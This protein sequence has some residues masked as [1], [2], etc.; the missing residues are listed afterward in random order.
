[1]YRVIVFFCLLLVGCLPAAAQNNL[2]EINNVNSEVLQ[3]E[4]FVFDVGGNKLSGLLDRPLDQEPQSTIVIVH[5]YGE[6]K[7]V[8][9]D[10]YRELRSQFAG[11]GMNVLIWDKPGCGDSE[12]E[13]DINQPVQSSAEEVVAAVQA[14]KKRDIKGTDKIGLWGISRAGWIAPLAMAQ[15]TSIAFW[16]SVSGTDDKENARYLL[17]SNWLAEGRS[18]EE[19]EVL[20]SEWQARFNTAWRNGTYQE[21]LDAAPNLSSDEFMKFMG[22][23]GDA[24]E[25]EFLAY[26]DKFNSGEL[27]VDEQ[28]ELMIYVPDFRKLLGSIN[29]PVLALFGE[30]DTNVDWRKTAALYRETLGANPAAS[31]RISTFPDGNHTL[32]QS[33][34]GGIRELFGQGG[35]APYVAGYYETMLSWLKDHNFGVESGVDSN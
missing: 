8:E 6:T 27:I 25:E 26:Q 10:W 7:V 2:D 9:Q 13:F 21:Y 32:K 15:D 17:A 35:D 23:A 28:E 14:L 33:Q 19:T 1:M 12:G 4:S 5:G 29:K 16:I 34:T 11:I 31:L 3:T 24:S 20:V 30:K 22:W 18:V